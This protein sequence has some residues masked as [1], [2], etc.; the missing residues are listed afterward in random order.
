MILS[1]LTLAVFQLG[2]W[3][4][5]ALVGLTDP[6]WAWLALPPLFVGPGRL[7]IGNLAQ[8]LVWPVLTLSLSLV[9]LAGL[10]LSL[11]GLAW[12][13]LLEYFSCALLYPSP[14]VH[15]L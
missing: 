9:G 12:L 3:R 6:I 11:P 7:W 4:R 2:H 8:A 10:G 5:L 15:T 13:A 1:F 14:N